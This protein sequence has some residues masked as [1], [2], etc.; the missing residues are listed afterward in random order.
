M[1]YGYCRKKL[2]ALLF[3]SFLQATHGHLIVICAWG[4]RVGNL[5]WKGEVFPG[6]YKCYIFNYEGVSGK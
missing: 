4:V 5:N 6:E 1:M 3:F 2:L